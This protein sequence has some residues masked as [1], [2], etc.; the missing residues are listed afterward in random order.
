MVKPIQELAKTSHG[1]VGSSALHWWAG[2]GNDRSIAD[3]ISG[4]RKAI[5]IGQKLAEKEPLGLKYTQLIHSHT[6]A[7][8]QNYM[9]LLAPHEN[10]HSSKIS[11][12]F[13]MLI[14]KIGTGAVQL[15]FSMNVCNATST[16]EQP[17]GH[18]STQ[19]PLEC[20]RRRDHCYVSGIW[21]H[22][23]F[24]HLQVVNFQ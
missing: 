10:K 22:L 2:V 17:T 8:Y 20:G 1:F 23:D 7:H 6:T 24:K 12:P 11:T 15:N 13:W 5:N 19:Q 3:C 9:R 18:C 14:L 21:R 4:C 16:V